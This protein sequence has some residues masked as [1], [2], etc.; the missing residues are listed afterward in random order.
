MKIP[1]LRSIAIGYMISCYVFAPCVF[2][3]GSGEWPTSI[4]DFTYVVLLAPLSAPGFALW[5]PFMFGSV[6]WS[7]LAAATI[8]T[9]VWL[10]IML[11][12][13]ALVHWLTHW[14]PHKPLPHDEAT[15]IDPSHDI[16][17]T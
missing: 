6:N 1:S 15:N 10:A 14:K 2:R 12:A 8:L 11:L 16:A 13:I 5:G 4:W 9:G 7:S 17:D 3:A